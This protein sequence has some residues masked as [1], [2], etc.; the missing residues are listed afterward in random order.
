MD[1]GHLLRVFRHDGFEDIP[2]EFRVSGG[3][4]GMQKQTDKLPGHGILAG[5]GRVSGQAALELKEAGV[6]FVV[7][8]PGQAAARR[9][10]ERGYLWV[11][12]DATEDEVLARAGIRRARPPVPAPPT[13][14]TSER[15]RRP[16]ALG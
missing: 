11:Q 16:G 5:L 15:D 9:T 3:R 14:I 4:R 13:P 1:A 8:D 7:A 6:P 10:E 2:G 12:G